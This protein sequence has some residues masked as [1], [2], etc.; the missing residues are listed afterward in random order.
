MKAKSYKITFSLKEG[1]D[2]RAKIHSRKEAE[3]IIK[4]W[5]KERLNNGQPV[6][7]GLLQEGTLFFPSKNKEQDV[8][9]AAPTA[10]FTGELS[11]PE[12]MKRSNREIRDTLTSL[13]GELK[14]KLKQQSVF[15]VYR[16]R[17][18]CV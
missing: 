12:D 6:I 4:S 15:V 2:S 8:V 7:S 5:L 16:D 14:V 10:I 9:T 13:A 18:W 3:R 11:E 1:Y 17:N